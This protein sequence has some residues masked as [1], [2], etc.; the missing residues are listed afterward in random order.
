MVN[1]T[2]PDKG[3]SA[4]ATRLALAN[5]GGA[6]AETYC[7]DARTTRDETIVDNIFNNVRRI[8]TERCQMR[9]VGVAK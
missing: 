5:G 4:P 3:P 2:F 9:I 1:K 7:D 6:A 8:G